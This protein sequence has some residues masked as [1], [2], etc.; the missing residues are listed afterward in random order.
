MII[1]LNSNA[2]FRKTLVQGKADYTALRRAILY[3]KYHIKYHIDQQPSSTTSKYHT[4]VP[5]ET[6]PT[7]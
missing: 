2:E 1:N 4:H 3:F 5:H 7:E 6:F